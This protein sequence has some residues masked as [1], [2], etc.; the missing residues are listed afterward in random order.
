MT[1][2]LLHAALTESV[3]GAFHEV[4]N[5]FKSGLLESLHLAALERERRG[6]GHRVAC[7]CAVRL[8][9]KGDEIEWLRLD[10]VV[11]DGLI[12]EARSTHSLHES[13]SRQPYTYLRATNP[14]VGLLLHFGPNATFFRLACENRLKQYRM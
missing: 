12:P 8:R 1:G 5:T 3:I 13:A 4:Y 7:E 14:D 9:Y 10:V 2:E 11:N 6:R